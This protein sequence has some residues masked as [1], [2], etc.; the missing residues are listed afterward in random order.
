MD[1]LTSYLQRP[2]LG[3]ARHPTLWPSE[4]SAMIEDTH[5]RPKVVGKCRR[6]TFFRYLVSNYKFY[7]KYN[8]LSLL[9]NDIEQKYISPD[10][11]LLWLWAAGELYEEYIVNLSKAAGIFV[12][13]QT[14]VYV[15]EQNVSGKIDVITINPD[16]GKK[17]INE[18]KSVYGFGANAVLG[19]PYERKKGLSGTPRDSNLMQ[20]ALYHWKIA[21]NN[22]NFENSALLYG[23]RDTGRYAEYSIWTENQDGYTIIKYQG[24]S[25][26]IT[27]AIQ[28]PITIDSILQDGYQYVINHLE[29]GEVPPRDYELQY[30]Q[31]K[32]N[33]LYNDKE[34]SKTDTEKHEK[35]LERITDNILRIEAGKK[36]LK[37]LK[38]IEKG[39]WQCDRCS[40][41][42]V[43]YNEN[44][45]PREIK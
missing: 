23:S 12:E 39:D 3:D 6:S 28:S 27:T 34:L 32:I 5:G 10:R 22:S 16:S 4:A 19:T 17:R 11:Y 8:H 29:A 33:E 31:E 20:I 14:Q 41:K 26:K 1:Y 18:I 35:I 24:I 30:T 15:P 44:Q 37:E 21:A 45:E 25:P 42:N 38:P 7:N 13:T 40:Y 2:K 9:V 43:C 36:P